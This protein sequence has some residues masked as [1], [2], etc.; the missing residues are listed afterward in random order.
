MNT[1]LKY[2]Y[3]DASNYKKVQEVIVS[4][5]LTNDQKIAIFA[6]C[7]EFDKDEFDNNFISDNAKTKMF[8]PGEYYGEPVYFIP[9]QVG[10]P[11]ERFDKISEDDH[12]W[13]ELQGIIDTEEEP[14]I[15]MDI[16]EVYDNFE[17]VRDWDDVGY[18]IIAEPEEEYDDI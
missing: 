18:A 13:F 11:E 14:T 7:N 8:T 16:K 3:R 2:M 9:Q 12:C 6:K 15:S 17:Q 1:K 10:L 5:T 4:G